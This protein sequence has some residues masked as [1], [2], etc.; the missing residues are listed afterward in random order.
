MALFLLFAASAAQVFAQES[1]K[2]QNSD[3]KQIRAALE[4]SAVGWNG[5]NFEKYLAIY[6]TDRPR[7]A[8][9]VQRA[10]AR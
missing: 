4:S 2:E 8:E 3:E 5:G 10:A 7:C 9:P 1:R 6:T